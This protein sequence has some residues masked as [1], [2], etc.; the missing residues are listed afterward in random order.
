MSYENI[1][2]NDKGK[3]RVVTMNRK[4]PLNPLDME[5]LREIKDAIANSGNR[6]ILLHGANRAFSAGADINNFMKLTNDTA[7][8]FAKEGHDI[9]NFISSYPRPVVAAIHGYCLGGGFELALACDLR[10]A[11]PDTTF[12]LP[13]VNLGILPGFGGTQ[14]LRHIVGETIALGL[15]ATGKRY[16]A[17]EA[18]R[19]GLL[20][21][22]S[23]D[24]L[25]KAEKLAEE[26]SRKPRE[27]LRLIKQLVRNSPDHRFEEEIDAFGT[28]F[29]Y[30]DREEGV[31]AFLDKREPH[32]Q[33]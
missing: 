2:V 8:V 17:D 10:I 32:F 20:N 12:G 23:E 13:E 11:H 22:V 21:E 3:L 26:L 18:Y 19:L 5:T 30:P 6:V 16:K 33:D 31:K 4:S 24:Y 25:S 15:I 27:S 1:Q 7:G 14:R 29:S 9:M 28:V